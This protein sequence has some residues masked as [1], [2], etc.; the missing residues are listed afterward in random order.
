MPCVREAYV[1]LHLYRV[2]AINLIN[3]RNSFPR[4]V[5]KQTNHKLSAKLANAI[6]DKEDLCYIYHIAKISF[7]ID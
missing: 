2:L 5:S 7:A 3:H 1:I 4:A 6:V